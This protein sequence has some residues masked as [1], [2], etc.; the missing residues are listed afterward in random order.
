[1]STTPHHEMAI[2]RKRWFLPAFSLFLGVLL[3]VAFAIGGDVG[4]GAISFGVMALLAA[5]F[6]FGASRSETIGG[7]GGPGR[8]ER[9]AM[10][11]LTAT[12]LA[13]IVLIVAVIGGFLYEVANGRD[14]S[15]YGQLGAIAGLAYILAVAFLRWRS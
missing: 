15:P 2:V 9:W 14:G 1:M 8:D 6:A 10:I 3:L 7:L 4:D 12:A 11:D 13:G 5:V